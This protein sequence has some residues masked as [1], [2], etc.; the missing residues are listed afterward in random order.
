MLSAVGCLFLRPLLPPEPAS[1]HEQPDVTARLRIEL[2]SPHTTT[3]SLLQC[4]KQ[5]TR[6]GKVHVR[7]LRTTMLFIVATTFQSSSWQQLSWQQF[8]SCYLGNSYLGI[9]LS[10]QQLSWQQLFQQRH[11]RAQTSCQEKTL[12]AK[13]ILKSLVQWNKYWRDTTKRDK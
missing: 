8:F 6:E 9:N 4:V 12:R 7:A 10:R 1:M 2:T 11:L 3:T 5:I 13:P